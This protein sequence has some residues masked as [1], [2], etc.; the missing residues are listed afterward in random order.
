MASTRSGVAARAM[1]SACVREMAPLAKASDV[2]RELLQSPR[3]LDA[4]G[5]LAVRHATFLAQPC[6]RRDVSFGLPL[7]PEL[8]R[9]HP[10]QPCVLESLDRAP[11]PRDVDVPLG[12]RDLVRGFLQQ[13]HRIEHTFASYRTRAT[14]TSPRSLPTSTLAA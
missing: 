2:A 1:T 6:R 9:P 3:E 12:G 5:G 7:A 14:R 11:Q 4:A 13:F 10:L 8:R